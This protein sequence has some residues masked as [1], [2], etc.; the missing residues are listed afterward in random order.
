MK[1]KVR[2]SEYYLPLLK[3]VSSEVKLRSHKYALR[4]GLVKQCGS[5]LYSWLPLGL[6]VLKNIEA[7]IRQ[8]L[9]DRGMLEMLM[10]CIQTAK[11]WEESGRYSDY[12]KELLKFRDRHDNEMLFGPT[13]EEVITSIVRD[14]ITSYKQL[15]K[16]LYHIQWKF[17]DEIRPR[18]GLMRAR[19]FLMKDAYSFDVDEQ[20]ARLSYDK[21]YQ[22]YLRIFN[23]LG[24]NPIPCRADAGVIGGNLNHEFH[25]ATD[26]GGECSI[27]YPSEV[28][29]LVQEFCNTDPGDAAAVK[30]MTAR[31]QAL[32]C[33]TDECKDSK[34]RVME[35]ISTKQGIEV[36]HIF[37]F[38]DK[39]SLPMKA[40][41]LDKDG[42][43]SN[44]YMGSY[45]IGISRLLA[46]I[47]EVHSDEKGI[48]WPESITP[49]KVG[50]INLHQESA[51]L[52][53]NLFANLNN[54]IYDDT[55][56]SQGV[57]FARMDLIGAPFQIIVGK[58][59]LE[60]GIVNLKYRL[61]SSEESCIP[62]ELVLRF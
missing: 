43:R 47:I 44:F 38:G 31:L 42:N 40:Q 3:E 56:D 52:A 34:D 19:E 8:E 33:F 59:S 26:A 1:D 49:F 7:I 36:G 53:E 15:P 60:T 62:D 48:I 55:L 29:S 30:A 32:D 37:L 20:S 25:I 16:I 61:D 46:A 58:R 21:V 24:L 23:R 57:K 18:F 35:M 4:A 45:G 14:S 17:R 13:N 10:P 54:V 5:G 12:G 11:L 41:F 9:D 22:A 2:I 28:E 27:F 51:A 6:R 39:Y 50:L